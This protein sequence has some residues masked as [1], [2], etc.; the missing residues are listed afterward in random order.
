M[1][2]G[3]QA[4]L[5]VCDVLERPTECGK[6]KKLYSFIMVALLSP[7]LLLPDFKKLSIFSSIFIGCC[8]I[9]VIAIFMFEFHAIY[10]RTHGIEQ[11]MTF[12]DENGVVSVAT[13]E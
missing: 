2:L 7:I 10:N 12:S 6:N 4:D 8:F 11:D 3:G 9:S 13:A 1:Y 5:L